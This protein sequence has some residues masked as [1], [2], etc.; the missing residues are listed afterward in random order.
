MP[1]PATSEAQQIDELFS[2]LVTLG[3]FIFLGVM[4]M[5][6]YAIIT[7]QAPP[8]DYSEGHP[9]RGSLKIEAL[10]T[11][12][13]ILLVLWISGYSF[14][15]YQ[16]MDIAGPTDIL[17]HKHLSSMQGGE[18]NYTATTPS[19][20]N[21]RSAPIIEVTAKQWAWAFRY[22]DK[23]VTST[24]LHL[25]VN[26]HIRLVLRSQDVLHGFYV[27]EFRIKQ[28]IIPGRIIN[29]EFTPIR[30]GKY[31]LKDSHFSGT[32]FAL[33]HANVYVDSQENYDRWLAV[34]ATQPPA[35]APN[36]A[37]AEHAESPKRVFSSNW[38]TVLP[39]APPI[40]NHS[41]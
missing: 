10:W 14:K 20:S 30:V 40:V 32:Y 33:M 15:I 34:A 24:E 28:D 16:R 41:S 36:L 29:F 39:A 11:I 18:P 25:P 35:P 2:F 4:G 21:A 7:C 22:P 6:G 23:N 12:T 37:A 3:T 9:A 26:Q 1:V 31:L 27:P 17:G 19:K 38:Y 8:D 13:P 5:L